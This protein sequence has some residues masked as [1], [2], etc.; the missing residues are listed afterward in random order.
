[1]LRLLLFFLFLF[2]CSSFPSFVNRLIVLRNSLLRVCSV[3]CELSE[4]NRVVVAESSSFL[5]YP[6]SFSSRFRLSKW[7]SVRWVITEF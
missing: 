4:F 1:M 2:S 7:W 5:F 3:Y 6:S